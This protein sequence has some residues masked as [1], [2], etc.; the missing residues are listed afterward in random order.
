[1]VSVDNFQVFFIY[2]DLSCL[3]QTLNVS[4]LILGVDFIIL[5][6]TI[7]CRLIQQLLTCLHKDSVQFLLTLSEM[8]TLDLSID[9]VIVNGFVL[10]C[11]LFK[12][13]NRPGENHHR[14]RSRC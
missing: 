5:T 14:P 9:E 3:F 2:L 6:C 12:Y 11:L 4:G 1:M 8:C 10:D 7:E 13:E